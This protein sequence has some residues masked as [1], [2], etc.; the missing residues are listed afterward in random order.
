VFADEP[1][2]VA[3]Q[4]LLTLVSDPLRRSVGRA[5]PDIS[6]T[7]LELSFCGGP[8]TDVLPADGCLE[9]AASKLSQLLSEVFQLNR[10]RLP[11]R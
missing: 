10:G 2:F 11:F 5:H 9:T 3:R 6:E 8:P 4:M 7:G 1:G